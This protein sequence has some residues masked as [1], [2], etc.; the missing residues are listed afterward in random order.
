MLVLNLD[1]LLMLSVAR[2]AFGRTIN[3]L[4]TSSRL[5]APPH[6]EVTVFYDADCGLC[7]MVARMLRLLD[8]GRRLRLTPL[9]RFE[10]TAPEEPSR[11]ELAA[12]LHARDARGRWFAG[13]DA[14][15][16]I[17]AS[18][19]ITYPLS[20]IGRLPGARHLADAG[21][22]LVA[23]NRDSIGRWLAV[24]GCRIDPDRIR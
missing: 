8:V 3:A 20:V 11:R 22:D 17:A 13:P 2:T 10:A 1:G 5:A 12:R 9:Q 16:R 19:P 24:D 14:A 15:L 6:P 23:N 18:I 21:Y 4:E 7:T